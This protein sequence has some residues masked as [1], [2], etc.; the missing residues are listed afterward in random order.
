MRKAARVAFSLLLAYL[1][2]ATI[3]PYFRIGPIILDVMTV[4]LYTAGFA[5]GMYTG[6]VAGLAGALLLE[7]LSGDLPGLSAVFAIATGLFGAYTTV[8]INRI[9][10]GDGKKRKEGLLDRALPA[11]A[12]FVLVLV[13]EVIYIAYF[14]LT[15]AD[16]FFSHIVRAV[17]CAALSGALAFLL[18]PPLAAFMTRDRKKTFIAN[19]RRRRRNRKLPKRFGPMIELPKESPFD[20]PVEDT[21]HFP[22]EL[23]PDWFEGIVAAP[24]EPEDTPADDGETEED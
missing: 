24:V 20:L 23:P 3:L 21:A 14:Y 17:R 2:Q 19:W 12:V 15:G 16:I 4:V 9:R 18:A 7:I 11:G 6:F 5:G 8:W 13:R 22:A 1:A 10:E